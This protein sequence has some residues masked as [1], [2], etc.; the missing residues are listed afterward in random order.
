MKFPT[1]AA[2]AGLAAASDLA[3]E[4][5]N[6]LVIGHEVAGV[7]EFLGL[8]FAQPPVDNLRFE[9]PLPYGEYPSGMFV[10]DY[11]APGCPQACTLPPGN[12]PPV[13]S[14]DCLFLNVWAPSNI[15][16]S[17]YPNGLPV[18]TFFHGGAYQQGYGVAALYNGT[19]L[20]H[21]DVIV[22]TPNYRLG[23]LGF[24][25]SESMSGNYGMKDQIM[26][27]QWVQR[28]IEAFGGN[29]NEVT[30]GGQSAGA[31][32]VGTIMTSPVAKGLFN[33]GIMESNPLALPYH[34]NETAKAN[35]DNLA[36]YVSCAIDDIA[37]FKQVPVELLIDAQ[38]SSVKLNLRD[39]FL[40]FLPWNPVVG[41]DYLPQQPFD[42]LRSGEVATS[43]PLL[44]GTV[45]NDGL[46][47][48]Y[49]LFP[50]DLG[51]REYE[52]IIEATFGKDYK[53]EILAMYPATLLERNPTDTRPVLDVLA[54]DLLFYCPSRNISEGLEATTGIQTYQYRYDHFFSFDMWGPDYTFCTG[55]IVC[56][57]SELVSAF[58]VY[59]D[60]QTVAYTPT[61]GELDL[62][63]TTMSYW[64][65]FMHTGNPN[66]GVSP[67]AVPFPGYNKEGAEVLVIDQ[68]PAGP[69]PLN[70]Q[71]DNYCQF[72]D[73]IGNSYIDW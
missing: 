63:E 67:V 17:K 5:D 66:K 48:V 11:A 42:A 47:F 7:R 4:T 56:H 8:R 58:N 22:V 15:D 36:E 57:G 69:Y 49:E 28:N 46:L 40:N 73:H 26:S 35:A 68:A 53:D 6:G 65:N 61:Q 44:I 31:M 71:R 10:A 3:V 29:P 13:M 39:L 27:L 12:C 2:I 9:D 38:K 34:N 45:K 23:A 70:H 32:S 54:T 72:W 1:F 30:I 33:K 21:K 55:D 16:Y 24:M 25:K 37:C 52:R 62:A 14:E 20:A 51:R 60:G 41:T 43:T 18:Y 64:T 19:S 50:K 59:T